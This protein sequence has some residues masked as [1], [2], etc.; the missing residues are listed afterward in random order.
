MLIG[1]FI[2][3]GI[4]NFEKKLVKK[5][6]EKETAGKYTSPCSLKG[7]RQKKIR[8]RKMT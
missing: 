4:N 3:L 5:L 8:E 7:E 6:Q 1:V 2:I